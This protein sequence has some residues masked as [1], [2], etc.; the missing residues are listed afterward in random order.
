MK[1]VMLSVA[2]CVLCEAA[3]AQTTECQSIPK[4][5]DRLACYDKAAPP[6][7]KNKPAAASP[8]SS[9]SSSQPGQAG[10]PLA[11]ENARLDAKINNIC[12]GC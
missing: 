1:S 7:S 11:A 4:A 9:T 3:I 2:L 5:S 10:D 12:R 6:T 8:T